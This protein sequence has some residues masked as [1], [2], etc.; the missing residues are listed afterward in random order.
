M[1]IPVL[2]LNPVAQ[3]IGW[4]LAL[5][6]A[7]AILGLILKPM[8]TQ[9]KT[10][11]VLFPFRVLRQDQR[12][13]DP[14]NT[15]S[16]FEYYLLENLAAGLVRDDLSEP[17]GYRGVLAESWRRLS[18]REWVFLL[19]PDLKWS[20]GSPLTAD[21]IAECFMRIRA[22][23][24]RHMVYLNHLQI[25]AP[26]ARNL[27]LVFDVPVN[28]G[29]LHELSLADAGIVS[30]ENL[31]TGWNITSGPYAVKSYEPQATRLT[32][33][34]N[35]HSAL[36]QPESPE[37]VDLFGIGG[38]DNFPKIFREIDADLI[39]SGGL[40]F[41]SMYGAVRKNAPQSKSGPASSIFY[42][43]LN[44]DHPLVHNRSARRQ[45]AGIVRE[46][47]SGEPDYR[48]LNPES[49]FIPTGFAGRLPG[50]ASASIERTG[51]LTGKELRVL[52]YPTLQELVPLLDK[53]K[54][55]AKAQGIDLDWVGQRDELGSDSPKH[56]A[57]VE[58]FKGNQKDALGSWS[59]LFGKEG[60]LSPFRQEVE[61]E[62]KAAVESP[63]DQRSAILAALHRRVLDE[64][65]AVPFMVGASE[66][67][68]SDRVSLEL[69]N[70]FDLRM[71]FYAVRW[72]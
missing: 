11:K 50:D 9:P 68:A 24:S 48:G 16:V 58:I 6:A 31:N 72:K 66:V 25:A 33:V 69:W 2:R 17:S 53:M 62:F 27:R 36:S 55:L 19:R 54:P 45:F 39:S 59:F 28:N 4:A 38:L 3:R 1:G 57:A 61:S 37:Q 71:R 5:S 30:L 41:T 26:D 35:P 7:A 42:F 46:A 15:H 14:S 40:A 23:P 47:F 22:N 49:Q 64:A 51:P 18:D 20:D 13:L 32:L 43:S 21:Q 63:E 65:W 67:F 44:A 29:L 70:P 60:A 52:V 10:L 34:K 12:L 8:L 56:F